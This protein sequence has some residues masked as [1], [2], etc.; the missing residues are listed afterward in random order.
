[1]LFECVLIMAAAGVALGYPAGPPTAA[2]NTISPNPSSHGAQPQSGNGYYVIATNLPLALNTALDVYNY[3][4]G[5]TYYG[6]QASW[7]STSTLDPGSYN[8]E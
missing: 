3:T 2:C 5:E 1:M 7:V 8:G 6:E 4:A